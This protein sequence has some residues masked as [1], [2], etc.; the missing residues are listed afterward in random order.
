VW[1]G[2]SRR[3]WERARGGMP[4]VGDADEGCDGRAD[5]MGWEQVGL[6]RHDGWIDRKRD[7]G[8]E[9]ERRERQR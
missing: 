3:E 9:R 7:R 4:G 6:G 8:R 5:V 2:R 1:G